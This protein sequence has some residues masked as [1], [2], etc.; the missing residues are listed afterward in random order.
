MWNIEKI[1][2]KGNYNYAVIRDHP[3][4]NKYG[5]VLEHRV[6]MENSIGRL[7]DKSEVVYHI[8]GDGHNND[9]A[10]LRLLSSSDHTQLHQKLKGRRYATVRCP[11]CL[12][13]FDIPENEL[14]FAKGTNLTFCSRYCNGMFYYRKRLGLLTPEQEI[15]VSENILKRFV[16]H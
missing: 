15:A 10:N 5:Y 6:V 16:R 4:A 2:K 3:Y 12:K 8:D 11:N 7:L 1:V 9:I 13:T 14:S